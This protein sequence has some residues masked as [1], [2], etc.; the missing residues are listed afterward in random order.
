M[1][2]NMLGGLVVSL[3]KGNLDDLTPIAVHLINVITTNL[4]ALEKV[5]P[6]ELNFMAIIIEISNIL[7]NNTDRSILP[8]EDGVYDLL[9]AKYNKLTGGMAPVGAPPVEFKQ[10]TESSLLEKK[11]S[12]EDKPIQIARRIEKKDE[13]LFFD[14]LSRNSMP[15]P[16]D[17]EYNEDN[18]LIEKRVSNVAH[19]YP[20]LVGTLDKCKFV[21]NKQAAEHGVLQGEGSDNVLVFERD[22]LEYHRSIGIASDQLIAEIKYDGVSVEAEVDGDTIISARSRGDTGNDEA[23]DLTPIFGGYKFHRATGYVPPGTVFGI[24]FEAIITYDN[25]RELKNRYGKSY[26]NA[27]NAIIGLLFLLLPGCISPG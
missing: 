4:L 11:G 19:N 2:G 24:K 12:N 20:E 16:S 3:R 22:F 27:R 15:I 26:K 21:L 5:N 13:M 10:E 7:Y 8:L 14:A 17:F 1:D 6:I 23:T 9:V 18:T 25:L